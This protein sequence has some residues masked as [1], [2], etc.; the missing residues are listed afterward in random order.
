MS[1][2]CHV[3]L[4]N[5]DKMTEHINKKHRDQ[6][7]ELIRQFGQNW[8]SNFVSATHLGMNNF[9]L[10]PS[11]LRKLSCRLCGLKH[12]SQDQ[13]ALDDHFKR[14][15][16]DLPMSQYSDSILF[17]CRVCGGML[18]GSE[19]HLLNHFREVHSNAGLSSETSIRD[20]EGS[21]VNYPGSEDFCDVLDSDQD[22]DKSRQSSSR[23]NSLAIKYNNTPKDAKLEKAATKVKV[24]RM[25]RR[26]LNMF[27]STMGKSSK[28]SKNLIKKMY[29]DLLTP[30]N[31]STDESSD[32]SDPV[33]T[34]NFCE[35]KVNQS[36]L[37]GHLKK[38]HKN[39]LFACDGTCGKKFYSAWKNDV[40]SHL[41]NVHDLEL[42]DTKLCDSFIKLPYNL[43]IIS[44]KATE[45]ETEAIFLSREVTSVK[46]MLTRHAEKRHRGMKIEDCYNL[47]CRVCTFVWSFN[48]I[49]KWEEHCREHH[50]L[51][52]KPD[53]SMVFENKSLKNPSKHEDNDSKEAVKTVK[54]EMPIP[55]K[56]SGDEP[57][58][59]KE[60]DKIG[61][62]FPVSTPELKDDKK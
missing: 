48:D 53:E 8:E 11:D 33:V 3:R 14:E 38:K 4:M 40:V 43:T 42:S 45:C 22:I 17:E 52:Q 10:L 24:R 15:H 35:L 12:L 46:K 19:T 55:T 62:G 61:E 32:V 41:K 13:S 47:G 20:L 56:Q 26:P 21:D 29:S 57:T 37:Q 54:V 59:R 23:N 39:N 25:A 31:T 58:E 6:V 7:E 9:F 16:P 27:S 28:K 36:L 2:D 18:F 51:D 50:D 60:E 5:L 44:C 30:G 49:Q 34:C 1:K